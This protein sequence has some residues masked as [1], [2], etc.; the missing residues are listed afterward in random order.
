MTKI[1]KTKKITKIFLDK[2]LI[3][4]S[5]YSDLKTSSSVFVKKNYQLNLY[6]VNFF[7]KKIF[8]SEKFIIKKEIR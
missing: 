7:Y 8:R 4:K 3:V 5:S 6:L 1:I 2:V